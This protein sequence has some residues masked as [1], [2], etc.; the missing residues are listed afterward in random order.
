MFLLQAILDAGALA[1]FGRLL[2]HPKNSLQ[3]EAA[4]T[5]SNITAGNTNQIQA[6]IE[7]Q[8]VPL[9]IEVLKKVSDKLP[10]LMFCR[11]F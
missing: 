4:W 2:T 8:L 6:V 10:E 1:A 7:A 11:I 9:V 3:K 5:I